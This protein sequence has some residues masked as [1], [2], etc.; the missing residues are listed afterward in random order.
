MELRG[1]YKVG[2][3]E[4]ENISIYVDLISDEIIVTDYDDSVHVEFDRG[5]IIDMLRFVNARLE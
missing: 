2:G 5:Q 4:F 3:V 1:G